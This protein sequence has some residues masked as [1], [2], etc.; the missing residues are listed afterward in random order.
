MAVWWPSEDP[1]AG[2]R[3]REYPLMFIEGGQINRVNKDNL[4][5]LSNQTEIPK[6]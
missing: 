6:S 2:H 3:E 5:K 4:E 1:G